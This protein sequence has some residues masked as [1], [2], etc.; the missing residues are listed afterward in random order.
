MLRDFPDLKVIWA[1]RDPRA[2]LVPKVTGERWE[3]QGSLESMEFQASKDRPVTSVYLDSM[4][5]TG[6]T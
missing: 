4:V 6:L 3:C 2:Q 5:A 1:N